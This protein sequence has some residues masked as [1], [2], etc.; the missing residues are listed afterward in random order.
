MR[1]DVHSPFLAPSPPPT[2]VADTGGG[3][4]VPV[5]FMAL[6][7]PCVG[8]CLLF[9]IYLLLLWCSTRRRMERLRSAE[10]VKSVKGKGLSKSE[11]EKLPKLTG[12]ELAVVGRTTECPVC[13]EEIE[14]GQPARL[15]P[16][17]NH[18]FHQL[19][20]DTWLSDHTVCPVCRTE[21]APKL[22]PQCSEDHSPC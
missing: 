22:P 9:L 19:C 16:G 1:L 8:V 10:Q 3:K 21:L 15:V 14:S 18:G 11:L 2:A 5:V 13:L 12:E 17:C 7:L 20:A 6:L 4:M